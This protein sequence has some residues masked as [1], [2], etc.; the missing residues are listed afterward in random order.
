MG[1]VTRLHAA[2]HVGGSCAFVHLQAHTVER[3]DVVE[4]PY[5]RQKNIK[6]PCYTTAAQHA[7][8]PRW[9]SQLRQW[10]VQMSTALMRGRR[11]NMP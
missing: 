5:T 11:H 6:C 4:L 3:R 1:V 9:A 8:P 2:G 7:L 10:R